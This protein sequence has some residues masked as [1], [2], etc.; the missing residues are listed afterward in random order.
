MKTENINNYPNGTY[1]HIKMSI[2]AL[3]RQNKGKT[4][5][6]LAEELEKHLDEEEDG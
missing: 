2:Q 4:A 6:R 5:L 3:R 1:W